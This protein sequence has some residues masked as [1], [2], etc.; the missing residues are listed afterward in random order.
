MLV[1]WL[2][3]QPLL[4]VLRAGPFSPSL[5]RSLAR[6]L[7]LLNRLFF[8]LSL[9]LS[10]SLLSLSLSF[11]SHLE[12]SIHLSLP[13]PEG[14]IRGQHWCNAT[15][16]QQR[17]NKVQQRCNRGAI[18][19]RSRLNDSE[20]QGCRSGATEVQRR[21]NRGCNRGC[22]RGAL[23]F[24]TSASTHAHARS[25][26]RNLSHAHA[27]AT[28]VQVERCVYHIQDQDT[29]LSIASLFSTSWLQVLLLL[30][31]TSPFCTSFGPTV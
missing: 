14:C 13:L 22:N 7:S 26:V 25:R 3:T 8:S 18:L 27:H 23:Y 19:E 16:L 9:S 5:A 1:V 21:R 20:A 29:L 15:G 28:Q 12:L 17:C 4:Q 24:L 31:P 6:S 2:A 11:H 30:L 10:L